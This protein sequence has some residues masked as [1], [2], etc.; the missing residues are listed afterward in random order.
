[1]RPS[2]GFYF[3]LFLFY[4]LSLSLS[5]LV[6]V[7]IFPPPCPVRPSVRLNA[8]LRSALDLENWMDG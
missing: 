5:C 7:K 3:I 6:F 4:F 1:M 8:L 2:F